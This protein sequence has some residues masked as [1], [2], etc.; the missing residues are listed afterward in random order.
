M[1]GVTFDLHVIL[2]QLVSVDFKKTRMSN[3]SR[4]VESRGL[5]GGVG[6]DEQ[7]AQLAASSADNGN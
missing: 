6:I 1:K 5:S 4:R 2:Y 7:D 3:F